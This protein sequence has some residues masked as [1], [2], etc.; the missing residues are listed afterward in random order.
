MISQPFRLSGSSSLRQLF[1]Y[2]YLPHCIEDPTSRNIEGYERALDLWEELTDNPPLAEIT[3]ETLSQFKAQ[4][5]AYRW[6]GKVISVNTAI[7]HLSH[8]Q[9]ILDQAGPPG[10]RGKERTAAGVLDRVPYTK[11]PKRRETYTE[12]VPT[13]EVVRLFH[14]AGEH[15]RL[16]RVDGVHPGHLW[17]AL[18]GVQ[19]CTSLRIGQCAAI[20]M[21]AVRWRE[22]ML[23][24]P[25]EI[26]RKSK[27]DEPKPV[28]PFVLK[29]LMRVR[30]TRELLFPLFETH[31]KKTIYDEL[32]RLQ[33]LAGVSSFGFHAVRAIT[34]TSLSEISPA[35]AQF[36]AGHASYQTTQTYQK[37]RLLSAAMEK[38]TIFDAL[39][40]AE[41][42]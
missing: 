30:G 37:V 15:A 10:R 41:T 17:Q 24:L 28:H 42:G 26:C 32:H 27:R 2:H 19:L 31:S 12:E 8:V 11:L 21:A 5:L 23:L 34:I 35:A 16:P 22:S 36:A 4:L 13:D 39:E 6:R 38:L 3:G 20:P 18:F 29:L 25:H 14:T 40:Q 9:W 1:R 7:K 33:D